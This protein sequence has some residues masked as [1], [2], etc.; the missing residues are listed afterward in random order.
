[1]L[2]ILDEPTNGLDPIAQGALFKTLDEENVSGAT[3]FFSSHVL[4]EV[5]K[6][7]KR[8]AIV[9]DGCV[10]KVEEIDAL[11]KKQ[12]K[13]V[14]LRLT[15]RPEPSDFAWDGIS[16]LRVDERIVEMAFAGD[17]RHLVNG[18]SSL[19]VEDVSIEDPSLEEIFLHYYGN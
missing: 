1:M 13:R 3:I 5:Q 17:A 9:R 10:V 16:D 19:P 15:Q 6:L 7:C 4:A 2:L 18:I 12:L 14:S 8:V 11:R